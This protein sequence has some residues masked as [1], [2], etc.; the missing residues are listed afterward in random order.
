VV[1]KIQKRL[2]RSRTTKRAVTLTITSCRR[3]VLFERSIN[4]FVRCCLD[5]ERIDRWLCIDSGTSEDERTRIRKRFPFFD[6]IYTEAGVPHGHSMNRLMDAVST[7]FWLHLEDDWQF[8]ARRRYIE[9]GTGVLADDPSIAQLAF[10]PNY[11]EL[12]EHLSAGGYL[13][14]TVNGVRYRLHERLEPGTPEWGHHVRAL[15][16]PVRIAASW[17]HFTLNPSLMRAEAVRSV[18]R[19]ISQP[20]RDFE[21]DFAWRFAASGLRTAFFDEISCV[22]IGRLRDQGPNEGRVSAYDLVEDG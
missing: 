1:D 21:L 5:V 20:G 17:P 13:R 9:E 2:A 3:P 14:R 4:S 8:V 7:P 12:H 22:H 18:G 10:N 15:P 11:A 6:F 16:A 19:F